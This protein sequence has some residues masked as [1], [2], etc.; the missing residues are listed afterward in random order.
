MLGTVQLCYYTGIIM[1]YIDIIIATPIAVQDLDAGVELQ[2]A[3][4]ELCGEDTVVF[5]Y[6]NMHTRTRGRC[7]HITKCT[8][9]RQEYQR[10]RSPLFGRHCPPN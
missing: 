8:T 1:V 6:S 2:I 3:V 10:E 9:L 4:E 7:K 5:R